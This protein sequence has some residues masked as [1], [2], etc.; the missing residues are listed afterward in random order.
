MP[1]PVIITDDGGPPF[2]TKTIIKSATSRLA[3]GCEGEAMPELENPNGTHVINSS[4]SISQVKVFENGVLRLLAYTPAAVSVSGPSTTI[5]VQNNGG[6][7]QVSSDHALPDVPGGGWDNYQTNDTSVSSVG[8][9][10]NIAINTG[11]DS[12][13]RVE[14]DVV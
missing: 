1:G 5:S 2:L 13:V 14:I 10:Q 7:V 3:V 4:N 6:G 9:D 12:S 11:A 8:I